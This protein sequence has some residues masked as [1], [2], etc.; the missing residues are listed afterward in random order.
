[1][2]QRVAHVSIFPGVVLPEEAH[3]AE[4]SGPLTFDSVGDTGDSV[5]DTGSVNGDD[6]QNAV[7]D[8]REAQRAKAVAAPQHPS[9]FLYNLGDVVYFNGLSNTLRQ[10]VL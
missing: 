3:A 6:I 2:P 8:A 1:M 4:Q 5:G 9:A 7:A 10:P